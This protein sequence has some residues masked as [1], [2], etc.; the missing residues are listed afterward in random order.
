MATPMIEELEGL[1]AE[2]ACEVSRC[3]RKARVLVM[4]TYHSKM[5]CKECS[6][7]LSDREWLHVSTLFGTKP[8]LRRDDKQL[9]LPKPKI[10]LTFTH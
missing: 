7:E 1:Q 2:V 8:H 4:W 6:V 10:A 3:P 9:R 5:T